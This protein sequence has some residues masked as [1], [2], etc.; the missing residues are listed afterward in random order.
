M[1]SSYQLSTIYEEKLVIGDILRAYSLDPI[2]MI[3]IMM[4]KSNKDKHNNC[5]RFKIVDIKDSNKVLANISV[6]NMEII[7]RFRLGMFTLAD[8]HFYF[9]NEVIKI[10]YDLLK[11][12]QIKKLT[13]H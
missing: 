6:K 8:G 11:Q 1:F 5:R 4:N 7:G 2:T 10:R 9:D 13:E 12:P 3:L